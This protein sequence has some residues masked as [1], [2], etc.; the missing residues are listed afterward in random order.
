MP[1]PEDVGGAVA[2]ATRALRTQ[3][4]W[5]LE[6]LATRAGVSKGMLVQIEQARTNPSLATLC[7][8]A[9]AFG[10]TLAQLVELS[11]TPSVRVVRPDEVVRLWEGND[12]S[13][14]DLLVG[15][16][17]REHVELWNWHLAAGDEHVSESHTDGTQELAAVIAGT[18]TLDVGGVEHQVPSGGAAL[19]AA[20]Q[21]HRYAN[22]FER[23]VR[24]VLVVLQPASDLEAWTE[25]GSAV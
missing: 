4:H 5:S 13:F 1:R 15:T 21:P 17:R 10:V 19:F 20:D 18:L 25:S 14:G 7:R 22:T 2:R 11:E 23:S 16:D 9:E 8:L 24:F 3:R 6:T 12:G